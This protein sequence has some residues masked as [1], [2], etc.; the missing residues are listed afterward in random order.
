MVLPRGLHARRRSLPAW[1]LGVLCLGVLV[2]ACVQNPA[3]G[4]GPFPGFSEFQGSK[5]GQV[6]WAGEPVLRTDSLDA[7]TIMHPP[8]CR[9]RFLPRSVCLAGLNK[10]TLDLT[11]LAG[12]VVR[13]QL[14]YRDHGYYGTRVVPSVERMP[15]GD[16]AVRLAIAPGELVQVRE[17]AIE[18]TDSILSADE[19]RR[20]LPLR[21]GGPF[22]RV[23]FLASA[24]TI[25]ALLQRRG[26]AYAQVLK[27]YSLDTQAEVANV[28]YLT[29]PGPVVTVDSIVILGA[30]RL[31]P[32]T[33]RKQI[34]V[35]QGQILQVPELSTSQRDLHQ[36]SIVNFASVELAPDSLQLDADSTTATVVVRIVEAAKYLLNTAA[37][38]GSIDCLRTGARL[39]D[40]NFIGGGRTFELSGS[41]AK[42]GVG[43]PLDFGL[44]NSLCRGLASDPF[45]KTLTYRLAADVVQPR[46]LGTRTSLTGNVHAERRAELSLFLRESVG[47]Q[48]AVSHDLGRGFAMGLGAQVERGLTQST[49][50]VFCVVFTACTP[51]EA[52]PLSDRRWSN[53]LTLSS[54]LDRTT[55]VGTAPRGYQ[56]RT[57]IAW[58]SASFGS[59]DRYLSALGEV[60]GYYPLHPGWNLS[61]RVQAG[62]FVTGLL[63]LQEAYIP[64]ERRFYGGGPNTVRGFSA[65]AL[66][67]QAYVTNDPQLKSTPTRYPLGGTRMVVTS[68]ELN[69]P[70]PFLPTYLR[71]A[72]FI[73]AGQVWASGLGA[74]TTITGSAPQHEP[75]RITPGAGIR[76]A[77]PVGPIRVDVGYN[78]YELARGPLYLTI[79]D[80]RGRP[81]GELLFVE[82][83]RPPPLAFID[84][85]QFHIAVGQAF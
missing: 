59:D 81:T 7:V 30:D 36:L 4:R 84:R 65:N 58:A 60:V 49:P 82:E 8:L 1:R 64:P 56:V 85:L 10:Y 77:T 44:A 5:V 33:V 74:S 53:A 71:L 66:G 25:R 16:V 63:G 23:D 6:I 31:S 27:N 9:I 28:Q 34:S 62:Q 21:T 52:A 12:D 18:G 83:Y 17:M 14:Y 54:S 11:E 72:A 45:S 13:L 48:L 39:T 67:P 70:S 3:A 29:V 43:S 51:E 42:I 37:G 24:D 32:R 76:F 15:T 22:R 80:S 57:G 35:R 41:A 26:Y 55:L 75:L 68:A 46:L 69:T 79:D 47:S 61:G 38:Y 73:D 50:A 2:A 20:Q 40:R 19:I 78:A